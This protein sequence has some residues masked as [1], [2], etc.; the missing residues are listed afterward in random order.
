MSLIG[1]RLRGGDHLAGCEDEDASRGFHLL[2]VSLLGWVCAEEFLLIPLFAVRKTAVA[3]LV[4]I[5]GTAGLSAL[6]L[7]RRRQKRPAAIL[8]LSVL[9]CVLMVFFA[10]SGG[11]HGPGSMT[12]L[13]VIL[14]AAWLLGRTATFAFAGATLLS[15]LIS[16]LLDYNGHPA[17]VYFPGAP[18]ALWTLEV[19]AVVQ[20]VSPILSLL[21]SRKKQVLALRDSEERFRSLSDASF[22][23]IM[24]HHEGTILDANLAFLRL[25]GYAEP[26]RRLSASMPSKF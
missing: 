8:F 15:T 4:L 24:I 2:L 3:V 10:F 1:Y 23:G 20:A 22:E 25:F 18:L 26:G 16:A 21:E 9:W 7:L 14:E 12:A 11:V 5:I 17:P 13:V 6:S 19:L